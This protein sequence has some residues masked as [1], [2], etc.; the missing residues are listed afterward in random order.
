MPET[1]F[2]QIH[3]LHSYAAALLNR[4]DS[5]L[6]KRLPYGGFMRTRVSS[7]CL[8][9]HWRMA[10]DIHNV[11]NI[12]GAEESVR[13]RDFISQTVM[14]P[15]READFPNDV[16]DTIEI[17]MTKLVYGNEADKRKSRQPLLFGM[18]EL[19]FLS[20]L[21]K[22]IAEKANGD[23]DKAENHI[24][25]IV[26]KTEEG[27]KFLNNIEVMKA[28]GN[29]KAGITAALFGRMI[30]SDIA[31]NIDAPIHVA[32][33][34]TVH[35]AEPEADYFTA[36]NDLYEE[37]K[38]LYDPFPKKE[39]DREF[40]STSVHHIN[41]TELTS[42]LFYGYV[43]IDVPGLIKNLGGNR[44]M[45]GQVIHHL[46]HLIAEV[47]PGAKL[48][49]T[50]PYGYA[51]LMLIEAG[52]RQ[53]RSLSAAFRKPCAPNIDS[54]MAVLK[55]HLDKLDAAYQTGEDRRAMQLDGPD[56]TATEHLSL[57]EL[58]SWVEGKI[59]AGETS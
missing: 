24:K 49:S 26:D 9:R 20:E 59:K 43:V 51:D 34:F 42:G 17:W 29:L 45:A 25:A 16:I 30:T 57:P 44:A 18:P 13:S 58:A 36:M 35:E 32:H 12:E 54:A 1:R 41:E 6:A 37:G 38:V 5:G 33:A 55:T 14:A 8:K 3:T 4:D 53:P 7:Q 48:G 19:R 15:L 56:L 27:K 23:A 40:E 50:A 52:D 31:A 39:S 21:A 2:I 46:T 10:D 28:G 47:S 22:E 11:H